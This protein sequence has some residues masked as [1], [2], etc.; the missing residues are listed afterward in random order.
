MK[1]LSYNKCIILL[2]LLLIATKI[3]AWRW[4]LSNS[5]TQDIFTSEYG[6]RWLPNYPYWFH[7]GMD[8]RASVGF[9]VFS[10]KKSGQN[11]YKKMELE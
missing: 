10:I 9:P 6:P 1:V 2:L 7:E 4:P 3:Y 8:L 11:P 5:I